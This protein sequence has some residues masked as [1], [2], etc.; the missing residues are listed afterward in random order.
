MPM[1]NVKVQWCNK[2]WQCGGNVSVSPLSHKIIN[3]KIYINVIEITL[4]HIKS[5]LFW[6]NEG[7]TSSF[8]CFA[9]KIVANW[10][11][12]WQQSAIFLF[13]QESIG[14]QPVDPR[15]IEKLR[16]TVKNDC[17]VDTKEVQTLLSNYVRTNLLIN[18]L[19]FY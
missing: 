19:I 9:F 18:L 11:L 5:Y 1:A 4:C 13:F 15:V 2:T 8:I 6:H 12:L 7:T 3:I 16:D 17:I 14:R 10:F